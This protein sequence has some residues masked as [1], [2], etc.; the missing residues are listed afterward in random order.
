MKKVLV[1][2]SVLL[3]TGCATPIQSVKP[4]SEVHQGTE[5]CIIENPDVR[6]GFISTYKAALWDKGVNVKMLPPHAKK[7]DCKLTSTY[8]ANWRWD[9]ALYMSYAKIS[10]YRDD[11]LQGEALYDATASGGNF[12]KF[13][14]AEDKIREMVNNLFP[15]LA[16]VKN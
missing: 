11:W 7:S 8:T 4:V 16:P 2:F 5:L 3:A 6:D 1:I 13:I 15:D 14:D 9:L 12:G 10:V